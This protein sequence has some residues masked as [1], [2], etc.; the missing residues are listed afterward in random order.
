MEYVLKLFDRV[1]LRFSAERTIDG[2]QIKLLGWDEDAEALLPLG[3]KANDADLLFWLR[4]R[5]IPK[6][7]AYVQNFLSKLHLNEKDFL[8]ILDICRGLSLNDCYWVVPEDDPITFAD[9]N[10]FDNRF[11]RVLSQIAFTGYGSSPRSGFRSSPEFTTNGMLPKAWRRI[12]GSI[13]L[14]KGGTS[15]FANTGLEPYSEFYA[16]QVAQAMGIEHIPYGLARWNNMLCSTCKLFTSKEVSFVPVSR[17]VPDGKLTA[18]AAYYESLGC[19]DALADM[20]LLDAVIRNTDR[21]TNNFGFLV[22][23]RTNRILGPAPLFDHGLS[24]YCYVLEDEL[25][26][27]LKRETY[28]AP[29]LYS[30]FD[31]GARLLMGPRQREA[32]RHLLTFRFKKHSHYNLP[33]NRL[34]IL[35]KAVQARAAALLK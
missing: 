10:L 23:S 26:D 20:L 9:C 3:M 17:L 27:A 5:T 18:I 6:N 24:L 16:A 19:K 13:Y 32:L 12:N 8:G 28:L 21:H 25:T 31:E 11:S 4:H 35:E 15:G 33:E 7:R 30:D 2:T 1:L 29:S 22:D 34:S 14:Y